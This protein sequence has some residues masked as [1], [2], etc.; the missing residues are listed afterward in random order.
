[1]SRTSTSSRS[2]KSKPHYPQIVSVEEDG[3]HFHIMARVAVDKC[4]FFSIPRVPKT[5]TALEAQDM[6]ID[7]L[8][9]SDES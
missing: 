2:K 6:V 7:Y 3:K 8:E 5:L 9:T 4:R 1:M